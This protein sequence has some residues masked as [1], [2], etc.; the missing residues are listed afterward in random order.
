MSLLGHTKA[1]LSTYIQIIRLKSLLIKTQ[2]SDS[3]IVN[4]KLFIRICFK[5]KYYI[6]ADC[7]N[8]YK[9]LLSLNTE[10]SKLGFINPSGC[11]I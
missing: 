4:P 11:D 9:A 1:K 2:L 5:V 3:R 7:F 10:L 8:P 6:L